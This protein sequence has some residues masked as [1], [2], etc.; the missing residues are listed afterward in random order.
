VQTGFLKD[1]SLGRLL[2]LAYRPATG[3]LRRIRIKLEVDTNPPAGARY[4]MPIMDFPFPSAIRIFD[5]PSLL[6]GK[7]HALLC[8]EYTKGRDW[9]DFIWYAARKI[10]INHD[11]LTS[12]LRQTGPWAG[13]RVSS[14]NA[15]C[16]VA[17]EAAIGRLNI[18]RAR[19]DVRRFI[20][21]ADVRS[22]ELWDRDFLLAQSRK[23]TSR[24]G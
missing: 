4:D 22:L 17:L 24:A 11:L 9:F 15:W 10:T 14:D 12:A 18:Q 1:D 2:R 20:K 13:Q 16:A 6:A 7:I 21:P 8:R 23:I 3:P 19:E 5:P